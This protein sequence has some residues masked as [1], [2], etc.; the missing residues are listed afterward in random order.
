PALS[1]VGRA[2]PAPAWTIVDLGTLP[3]DAESGAL[4]INDSGQVVG[5]SSPFPYHVQSVGIWPNSIGSANG[6][7]GP[8]TTGVLFSAGSVT[9][10]AFGAAYAVNDSGSVV[11]GEF[12]PA[13]GVNFSAYGINRTGQVAGSTAGTGVKVSAG[14]AVEYSQ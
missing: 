8:R 7:M 12:S 2:A 3:G 5:Y 11:G 1:A 13:A 6:G 9:P 4:G 14:D 10:A